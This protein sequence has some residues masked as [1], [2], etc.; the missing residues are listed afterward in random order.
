MARKE[1]DNRVP[2]N[3]KIDKDVILKIDKFIEKNRPTYNSRNHFFEM[4]VV[5]FLEKSKVGV[6]STKTKN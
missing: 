6:D 4:L 1:I 3:L 5:E 2:V